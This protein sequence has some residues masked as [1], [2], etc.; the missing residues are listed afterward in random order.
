[1]NVEF[2]DTNVLV[3]AY[4]SQAG[5]RHTVALTLITRVLEE[6]SAALS[7]Q[8]LMEFYS[9]ATK[10]G[11]KSELAAKII[12]DLGICALHRPDHADVIRA[13][14]LLRRYKI[15]WWDALVINSANQL[16]CSVLWTEDLN[17]GQRYGRVTIRNPFI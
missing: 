14:E 4:D 3:Y 7:V 2:I 8:I 10:N 17:H 13:I 1:M 6:G 5:A 15:S 9:A 12:A 16:N 11:M